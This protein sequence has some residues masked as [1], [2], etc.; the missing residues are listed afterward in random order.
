[1]VIP[2]RA[3]S[4]QAEGSW[5]GEKLMTGGQESPLPYYLLALL[6]TLEFRHRTQTSV[7]KGTL[8]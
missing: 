8:H 3:K 1:M 6:K 7:N 2:M 5:C 4:R